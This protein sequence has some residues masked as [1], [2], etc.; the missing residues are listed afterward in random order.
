MNAY[1]T[2]EEQLAALKVFWHD[3][4]KKIVVVVIVAVALSV[5][6][7]FYKQRMNTE[8]EEASIHYGEF[9]QLMDEGDD[10]PLE[11]YQEQAELIKKE[12]AKTPYASS[13]A[14][15]MAKKDIDNK[16]IPAAKSELQWVIE[17]SQ[18]SDVVQLAKI[19]IARLLLSEKNV[20]AALK[21]VNDEKPGAYQS[22]YY[23]V[24]GDIFYAMEKP[25]QARAA[26]EE[27]LK[28]MPNAEYKRVVQMKYDDLATTSEVLWTPDVEEQAK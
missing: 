27:A 23:E 14:L 10:V 15:L 2:E 24:R 22:E 21:E 28:S 19:R 7:S 25:A 1:N 6:F 13:A 18:D 9:L 11:K 16:D 12:Y 20:E 17:H 3:Y 8:R 26:Y 5:A 4:G